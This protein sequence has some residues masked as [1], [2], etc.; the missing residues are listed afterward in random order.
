MTDADG[1]IE[2]GLEAPQADHS[3]PEQQPEH[4]ALPR[5]RNNRRAAALIGVL[6]ALL[7]FGIAVQV[8]SNSSSDS[9]STAQ[10]ADLI[11][12]LD[13]QNSRADRL[14]QQIAALQ[15]TE[16]QLEASGNRDSVALAQAQQQ[17]QALSI[18]LGTLAATGP[19]ITIKITDPRHQLKAEDLL[20]VVEELRGAGAEAIQFGP[21]RISTSSA[22][23]DSSAGVTVDG[24][25][26]NAPYTVVAIGDPPT[27]DTAMQI[28][29]GVR[30]NARAAGGDAV[31]AEEQ[32]LTISTVRPI[33][34]PSYEKSS[35]R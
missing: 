30:A 5:R 22:F 1:S 8:R 20:D 9:L 24:T 35:G 15:A 28:P 7:G 33:A 26:V 18:L 2:P 29:G 12:I 3:Q 6:L 25:V 11:G 10:D 4:V 13:D 27:L 17:E 21:V 23:L 34:H 16:Q 31:I 32:S 19:G 14:R